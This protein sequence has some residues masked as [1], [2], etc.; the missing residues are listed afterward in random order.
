M[1]TDA[2][3]QRDIIA[4][5]AW[6]PAANAADI[7]VEAK[8]GVVTLAGTVGSL[9]EKW[10]AEQ[11]AQRVSGVK[12][13]AVEIVV[14]LP[15]AT[16]Q[17]DA[18]LALKADH[19][20]KWCVYLPHPITVTAEGGRITLRGEMDWEHER[21]AAEGVVRKLKGVVSI[22]DEINLTQTTG[23]V[24]AKELIEA[25]LKRLIGDDAK[26]ISVT[27]TDGTEVT[28]SGRV[29]SWLERTQAR[30]SAWAAP[31]VRNVIDDL[32]VGG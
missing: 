14:V 16:V 13:L 24:S 3:L 25:A 21:D 6:N 5:L 18:E 8:G 9:S 30:R 28:M 17:S 32:V 31:G 29:P 12:A 26:H 1:K 4:E 23:H 19:A 27:V 7:G 2:E 10:E 20:L 15:A 22:N 11:A